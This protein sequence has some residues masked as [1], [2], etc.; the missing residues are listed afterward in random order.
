MVYSETEWQAVVNVVM[1]I[2][3]Q[4]CEEFLAYLRTCFFLKQ[5]CAA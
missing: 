3:F 2:P 5:H 1:N 4:K